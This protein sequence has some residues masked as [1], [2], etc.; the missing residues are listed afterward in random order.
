MQMSPRSQTSPTHQPLFLGPDD[1]GS[2]QAGDA[3]PFLSPSDSDVAPPSRLSSAGFIFSRRAAAPSGRADEPSAE[4]FD[5]MVSNPGQEQNRT[6]R[7]GARAQMLADSSKPH[8]Q[9]ALA[10]AL[11]ATH[12]FWDKRLL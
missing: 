11:P 1:G 8:Q 4:L 5:T 10:L 2:E 12:L 3:A 7:R 9:L 6:C